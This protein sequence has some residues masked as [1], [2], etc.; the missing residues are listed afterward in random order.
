MGSFS[1]VVDKL[2][3]FEGMTSELKL[4]YVF[5]TSEGR[6]YYDNEGYMDYLKTARA[7]QA[8]RLK[9][10]LGAAIEDDRQYG[11]A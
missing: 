6:A 8:A 3:G 7:Y 10:P 5:G 11:Q 9:Y 1:D 4:F 2:Y